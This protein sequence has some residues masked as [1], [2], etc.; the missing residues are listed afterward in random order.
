MPRRDVI[1]ETRQSLNEA[2]M[3]PDPFPLFRQWLKEADT[4]GVEE[5]A[6]MTLATAT[7]EGIPSARMVLLRG[8]DERGFVF[9]TNYDSRKAKELVA[10][11]RAALIFYWD[12][13][14]RQIRVEGSVERL[15]SEESD[16]YF[17]CRPR[18]SCI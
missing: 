17:Q 1:Q 12:P 2:E 10:N 6:A 4:V 11:P 9:H 8:F 7:P 18:E 16:A 13:L 5:P 14:R 15:S 3:G